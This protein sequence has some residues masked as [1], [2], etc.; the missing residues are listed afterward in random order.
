M[1][2]LPKR[3]R[4]QARLSIIFII[5]PPE[6]DEWAIPLLCSLKLH[7][8]KDAELIAYVPDWK[9]PLITP[10]VRALMDEVG[11]RIEYFDSTRND[12]LFA[13]PYPIG[14]KIIACQA[15]RH[16]ERTLFLDT[17]V[18]LNAPLDTEALFAGKDVAACPAEYNSF[19]NKSQDWSPVYDLFDLELPEKS[20]ISTRSGKQMYPYFNAGVIG[21]SQ[22]S[23]FA[24]IWADTAS[25]IDNA[26]IDIA[27][28]PWLDQIALPV[29]LAR[30]Q[31]DP[32]PL[33][34]EW[35]F[36]LNGMKTGRDLE[37][38]MRIVHFH[39]VRFLK[40]KHS[41]ARVLEILKAIMGP[42]KLLEIAETAISERNEMLAGLPDGPAMRYE[43]EVLE[44][45]QKLSNRRREQL[46]GF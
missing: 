23:N 43:R 9:L 16:T 24:E 39:L 29:A 19:S 12:R 41:H 1:L 13:S 38:N 36:A 31:I 37:P 25:R 21:F 46:V 45:A 5:D 42:K 33:G 27:K 10:S 34:P 15:K 11:V 26:K 22:T 8:P 30:L 4:K 7:A 6:I 2:R 40:F 20:M 18:F 17:D 35:N 14:N 44:Y 32:M 28:R 3:F